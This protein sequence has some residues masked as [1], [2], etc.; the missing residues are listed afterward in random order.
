MLGSAITGRFG[1]K[2]G[3]RTDCGF[4]RNM[5]NPADDLYEIFLEWKK[6]FESLPESNHPSVWEARKLGRRNNSPMGGWKKQRQA[7]R[8]LEAIDAIIDQMEKEGDDVSS[9]RAYFNDWVAAVFAYP[10][11]WRQKSAG[12]PEQALTSLGMFRNNARRILPDVGPDFIEQIRRD[13]EEEPSLTPPPGSYPAD[14]FAYFTRVR[15]HLKHC[16]DNYEATNSFDLQQAAEHYRA[17]VF[18]MSNGHFV[19][20]PADWGRFAVRVYGW[21]LGRRFGNR[22]YDEGANELAKQTVRQLT[23][24]VKMLTTGQ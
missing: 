19:T 2:R 16:I 15:A 17:A 22:V 21:N 23:S 18:M 20:N 24:A 7:A 4:M 10:D 9:E 12:V 13:L 8:C 1:S 6:E 3:H 11:G 14:L 5:A